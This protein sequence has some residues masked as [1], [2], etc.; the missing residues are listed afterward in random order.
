MQKVDTDRTELDPAAHAGQ[1]PVRPPIESGGIGQARRRVAVGRGLL[2]RAPCGE[3]LTG[4]LPTAQTEGC[5]RHQPVGQ[6]RKGLL[7]GAADPSSDPNAFVPVVV[8][9]AEPASMANDGVFP[10]HRATPGQE[11]QRNYPGSV[12]SFGSGSEINRITAGV[13]A[14]R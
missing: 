12:L 8:T 14:R 6:D 7:T 5:R 1:S 3:V 10:A 11:A 13:K 2:D 9:V 4:Q